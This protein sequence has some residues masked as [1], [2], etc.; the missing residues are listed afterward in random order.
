[1]LMTKSMF[2]TMTKSEKKPSYGI[3]G[4]IFQSTPLVEAKQTA[5]TN[6]FSQNFEVK[7]KSIALHGDCMII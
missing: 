7:Y 3:F 4:R 5:G 2:K 1:M 6:K